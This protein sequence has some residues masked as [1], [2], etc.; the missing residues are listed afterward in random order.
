MCSDLE[1]KY[2]AKV[3]EIFDNK[4]GDNQ[5]SGGFSFTNWEYMTIKEGL[6]E[7]QDYYMLTQGNWMKL[8]ATFGGAPEIPF[9]HYHV[10]K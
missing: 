10:E 7:G 8:K 3:H 5:E 1:P 2:A 9:F 6:E 4:D